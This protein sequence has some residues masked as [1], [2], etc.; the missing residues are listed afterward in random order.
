MNLCEAVTSFKI[1]KFDSS[2][3]IIRK[4]SSPSLPVFDDL[5]QKYDDSLIFLSALG[6]AVSWNQI[7]CFIA[8]LKIL[9]SSI[10]AWLFFYILIFQTLDKIFIC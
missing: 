1:L 5:V 6:E 3:A 7:L 2:G 4:V 10:P 9:R 8:Y